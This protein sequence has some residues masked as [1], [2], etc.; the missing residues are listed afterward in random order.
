MSD[1]IFW[2]RG[3]REM[4]RIALI[5]ISILVIFMGALGM[6]PG[7]VWQALLEIF[8]GIVGLVI[9]VLVKKKS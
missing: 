3:T 4:L 5:V 8:I 9:S 7:P 1:N 2:Q 6:K